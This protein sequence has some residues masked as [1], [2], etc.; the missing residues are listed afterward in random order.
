MAE[1]ISDDRDMEELLP[2]YVNDT[3]TGAEANRVRDYLQ[4]NERAAADVEMLRQ[5]RETV[6]S[7]DFGSPGEF[8]LRRLKST[9]DEESRKSGSAVAAGW[10]W[11]PAIAAAVLVIAVQAGLLIDARRGGD[12]YKPAGEATATPTI[13]VR[14]DPGA[15]E[16]DIR[17]L[18]N[19]LHIEIVQGPGSAG[20]YRVTAIRDD[21]DIEQLAARL[22]EAGSVVTHAEID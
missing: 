5:V 1:D 6:K 9:I 14:F 12:T 20:V 21:A 19:E 16:R 4:D 8:G 3:L 17:R 22:R 10:W 7:Q 13:Q 18:L 11:R 2:W 15:T